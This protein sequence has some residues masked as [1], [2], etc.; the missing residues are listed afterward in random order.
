MKKDVQVNETGRRIGESHPRAKLSDH[1]ID[2]IR[3][4]YEDMRESGK[5]NREA[6]HEIAGKFDVHWRTVGKYVC[7]ESRA[8]I[9]ARA[10]RVKPSE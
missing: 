9:P 2:L 4:L 7:C 8:Q 3:E 6:M 5:K 10:K 1:E